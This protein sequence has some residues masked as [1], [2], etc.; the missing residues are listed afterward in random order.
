M[1]ASTKEEELKKAHVVVQKRPQT[2]HWLF[3]FHKRELRKR[4]S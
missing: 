2:I 4:F 1:T 3:N